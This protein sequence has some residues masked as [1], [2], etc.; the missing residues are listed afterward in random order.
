MPAMSK[1][2][3]AFCCG[4]LWRTGT[5]AVVRSLPTATLGHEV[6]EIGSGNG[7]VA[8]RLARERREIMITATDLDPVMVTAATAR[9]APVP[10]ATVRTADA[11]AL[12]FPDAS[13]DSVL[14]ALMLHHVIDWEAALA[15]VARVLRPGGVFVGY[16]LVR[17]PLA[18]AIH[19]V[20]RS[21]FRLFSADEFSSGCAAV[22]LRPAIAT[23]LRG[24]V[25]RFDVRTA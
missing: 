4:A 1:V 13:F 25:L 2:E 9:L 6:L 16:D 23:G 8:E 7:A 22:G 11:T 17:T 24:H 10:N 15:E 3:R 20:D 18:T 19:R 5:G 14:S 21:P 12:P